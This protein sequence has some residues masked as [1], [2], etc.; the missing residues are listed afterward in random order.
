MVYLLASISIFLLTLILVILLYYLAN[1]EVKL[2]GKTKLYFIIKIALIIP[3][4][5]L[6]FIIQNIFKNYKVDNEILLDVVFLIAVILPL[7]VYNFYIKPKQV[8]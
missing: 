3:S 5:S 7:A 1:K 4:V 2:N 8:F 6:Y